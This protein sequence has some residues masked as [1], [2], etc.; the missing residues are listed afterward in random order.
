MTFP[1]LSKVNGRSAYHSISE[2]CT[3]YCQIAFLAKE[4]WCKKNRY[5]IERKMIFFFSILRILSKFLILSRVV[6]FVVN[7]ELSKFEWYSVLLKILLCLV[8]MLNS[9]FYYR[10]NKYEAYIYHSINQ[11]HVSCVTLWFA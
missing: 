5:P 7:F 11:T 4:S 1:D 9:D 6:V 10:K 3:F 2:I 8:Q